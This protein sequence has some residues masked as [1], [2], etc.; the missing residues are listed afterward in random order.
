[1]KLKTLGVSLAVGVI[2]AV[3]TTAPAA[4]IQQAAEE[5]QGGPGAVPAP[6]KSMARA[7]LHAVLSTLPLYFIEN[8]G[9]LD[10]RVAYYLQ[11]RG[12]AVYFTTGGITFAFTDLGPER[13]A[14]D[15]KRQL[16]MRPVAW[17]SVSE[18]AG[19]QQ[20]WA[21]RLEF[22]GAN[23]AVTPTGQEPTPARISYFKGPEAQ[24]K[25]DLATYASVAYHDLW[26]GIDLVYGGTA[27]RLK[28][29]FLV[30]PGADPQQIRLAYRGA[31]AVRLSETGELEID[32]PAGGF[33][34]AVPVSYQEVDGKRVE[35]ATAYDLESAANSGRQ[36]YG[37][38]LGD[39]DR[40][41]PLLVD[42]VVLVYAGYIG[43]LGYELGLGIAVDAAG[44]AYVAGRTG[45]DQSTFPVTV[46]PD[47]TYKG[48][49]DAFVA[50]VRADGT[51]LVY[52]GYIGGAGSVAS[53][54][55]IA[56]DAAGN[57]YVAGTVQSIFIGSTFPVK[58]GPRLTYGGGLDAFVA[59]V[60]ADGTGLVYCGYIGGAVGV[61]GIAVD[62][63]GNA[64]VTGTTYS[65]QS[66]FPV[67]VGP[68][69]T[70]GGNGDAFVA[71]V[72]AD[73]TGFVYAG[74][75]GGAGWDPAYGIAVDAAGSAYVVGTTTSDQSTFPVLV[76]PD[77]TFNGAEDAFVA[78]VRA[79]GT[80]LVYAGYIGGAGNDY[81]QGIAVDAAG[82]A[83]VT[84]STD[85]T[86]ATFPVRVGPDLTHNGQIDAFVAKVR[87]D[88]T[89]LVYAGY[90]GGDRFDS[91]HGIAVDGAGNA[92]VTG[93]TQSTESS[94]PVTV[95]PDLTHN[96]GYRYN[97]DAFVAKVRADG[98]GLVY[99]GY[100]GGDDEDYG[101][102]IAVDAV[103]NAYVTGY[104]YSKNFPVTVGP[105]LTYN[106][107][108]DAF[109]AK[110]GALIDL[111]GSVAVGSV[112]V[113]GARVILKN[114][115]TRAKL[116][117]AT[118]AAGAYR[119]GVVTA[120]TY[121]IVIQGVGV[122]T[123]TVSGTVQVREAPSVGTQVKLRNLNTGAR[124]KG[125]TDGTGAFSFSGVAPGRYGLTIP[126]LIVP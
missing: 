14:Q 35:V 100:I 33:Q 85:S 126:T 105:D 117:M 111:Q 77:L 80:G 54:N 68:G 72:R 52:A 8:R 90:I 51:G 39:Y 12:T 106:G 99:A 118:D 107:S 79:D 102:R 20:R 64:Y 36:V 92:Y 6:G 30:K 103:G 70:Y 86:E 67:T 104:T 40:S 57:A 17:D 46:G 122:T 120:G 78:K 55:G 88:G 44:N 56:V 1:M 58:V 101:T 32:T 63:V 47:L 114:L 42:P 110:V 123:M 49:G 31:T 94:F 76:G 82:N 69:L 16:P 48:D 41:Q 83:Y 112:P 23:P 27:G 84:G 93:L 50:K 45:S 18:G 74:Y 13:R 5:V 87:A 43:G 25:T 91:G 116:K 11:G 125:I 96:G 113:V 75:I 15:L 62:A 3:M 26:P 65:D 60:R 29:T 97:F 38:R 21:V 34:D 98:T 73:G 4:E 9:Q 7:Q 124:A 108:N 10:E 37:F 66:T 71:K 61:A 109:V 119:F 2:F 28:Y 24:W 89:G 115:A 59:K 22:V 95:G 19:T 121:S 53:A 81:G